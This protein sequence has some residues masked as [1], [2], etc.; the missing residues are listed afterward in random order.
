MKGF[1][2]KWNIGRWPARKYNSVA[3]LIGEVEMYDPQEM[4][5]EKQLVLNALR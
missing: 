2:K 5:E 1:L 3:K 4:Q